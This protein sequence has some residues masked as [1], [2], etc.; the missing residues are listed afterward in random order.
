MRKSKHVRCGHFIQGKR[1]TQMIYCM[2]DLHGEQDIFVRILE[3]IRFSDTDHLY[4]LGNVI[5][6][7]TGGMDILEQIK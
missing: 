5:D 3:L 2:A 1:E 7:G 6:Q 4:I